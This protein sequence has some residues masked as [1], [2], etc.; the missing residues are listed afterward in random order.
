MWVCVHEK[1]INLPLEN[2]VLCGVLEFMMLDIYFRF[3]FRLVNTLKSYL[4]FKIRVMWGIIFSL[5]CE[6]VEFSIPNIYLIC[7]C[8]SEIFQATVKKRVLT[9]R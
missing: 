3:R 5:L 2:T 9:I 4:R 1:L 8:I 7:F 6:L